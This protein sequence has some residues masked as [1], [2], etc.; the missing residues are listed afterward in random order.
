MKKLKI[1]EIKAVRQ[2][3]FLF[4]QHFEP[5]IIEKG[6]KRL[7]RVEAK[8]SAEPFDT[9]KIAKDKRARIAGRRSDGFAKVDV[10]GKKVFNEEDDFRLPSFRKT[11]P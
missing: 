2:R 7:Q 1:T 4:D 6:K 5:R 11:G 3:E 9:L 10:V 8:L